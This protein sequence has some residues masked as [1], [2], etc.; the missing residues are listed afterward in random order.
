MLPVCYT[1]EV[2]MEK[3]YIT[4]TGLMEY[5]NNAMNGCDIQTIQ[6]MADR[7]VQIMKDGILNQQYDHMHELL[8]SNQ[9]QLEAWGN[10]LKIDESPVNY[11]IFAYAIYWTM[12]RLAEELYQMHRKALQIDGVEAQMKQLRKSSYFYPILQLLAER[13]EVA[14]GEIAK[15]LN[16]SSHSLSNFLRRNE[17]YQLW[18]HDKYGKYNYYYLTNTGKQYFKMYRSK[19]VMTKPSSLHSV[20]IT[21]LEAILKELNEHDP[22]T[23]N[24]FHHINEKLGTSQAILGNELEKTLVR[25]IFRKTE[26]KRKEWEMYY[27]DILEYEEE[28]QIYDLDQEQYKIYDEVW[29]NYAFT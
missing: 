25:K 7:F 27:T 9:R 29:N 2:R 5:W 3:S 14:Q 10:I 12:E 22:N 13:G 21:L 26:R 4:N 23:E 6:Q 28:Q 19:N 11:K 20:T 1:M 8:C 18:Q 24:V 16:I 15:H 17:K